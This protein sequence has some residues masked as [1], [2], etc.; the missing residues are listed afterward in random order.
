MAQL[1]GVLIEKLQGG[2]GRL[3]AGTDDHIAMVFTGMTGTPI[4]NDI[5]NSG[6]GVKLLGV[7]DAKALGLNESFDDNNTLN[8][9]DQIVEFFRLAPS[10]TLYLLS[11]DDPQDIIEFLTAN[12]EIKGYVTDWIEDDGAFAS[13]D[14]T[15]HQTIIDGFAEDN[16]LVDF[17]VV[18]VTGELP[19]VDLFDLDAPNVSVSLAC[20]KADGLAS[21]GA[22]AGMLAIRKISENLGSVDVENKPLAKRGN[23]DYSLTDSRLGRWENAFLPDGRA[24]ETLTK[25]ELKAIIDN[26]YIVA[27]SYE[28]YPGYFFENSY[29]AV[30]R[31]SD[32]AYIENNRVWN[33]AARIIRATLL[34]RVK[35]KVK[36]DPNTGFIASTTASYWQ[37]L[38]EKAVGQMLIDDDISGYEIY[39]DHK[40]V[41]NDTNPVKVKALIVADGIVHEF[42]VAVGLTNNV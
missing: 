28:G 14:V 19:A 8:Y 9:F 40:Q 6:K 35:S 24:I 37:T 18:C 33:K 26:G 13:G 36:K 25:P 2:L 15:A 12:P 17:A 42:E 20:E 29:T 39:I 41:V 5:K 32:F 10:G 11:T 31:S 22:V 21:M 3:A 7:E 27:A 4:H 38:L 16:R 34:P 1:A 30:E 23:K